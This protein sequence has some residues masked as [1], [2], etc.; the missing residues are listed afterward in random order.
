MIKKTSSEASLGSK[1]RNRR[2]Q[3]EAA[4][5][6]GLFINSWSALEEYLRARPHAIQHI[7]YA[8]REEKRLQALLAT[9]QLAD[10]IQIQVNHG[11]QE[12]LSVQVKVDELGEESFFERSAGSQRD[13]IVACD[14]ITDTR[15]LGAIARSAAFFGCRHLLL[16]RDRQAPITNATLGAAQG[17][18]AWVEPVIVTNLARALE[19]LKDCGYWILC[20]DMDGTSVESFTQDFEKIVL[21]LGSE[22]RGVSANILNRS[23]M[24]I[25]I[26][27][28]TGNLESLNV[29][30]A[31]GI[32][33]HALH[34]RYN[35]S[36]KSLQG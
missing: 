2:T 4:A 16:P 15:N 32:L 6:K 33:I 5:Q 19:R 28:P 20:A 17:A 1:N 12:G 9:F 8:A 13:I 29:S 24:K 11:V 26:P 36:Q 14:H 30:V 22:E 23:D 10:S 34:Q 25:A 31:A 21:V 7:A 27:S 18:F 3:K 35:Q